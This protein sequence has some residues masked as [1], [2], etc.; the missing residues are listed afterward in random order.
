MKDELKIGKQAIVLVSKYF[1]YMKMKNRE[2]AHSR[3]NEGN[4]KRFPISISLGMGSRS[5]QFEESI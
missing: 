4:L 5:N 1:K 3:E 2:E